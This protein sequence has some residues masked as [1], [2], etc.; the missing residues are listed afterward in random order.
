MSKIQ[1]KQEVDLGTAEIMTRSLYLQGLVSC[2]GGQ[3]IAGILER[4]VKDP[5]HTRSGFPDLTLWN[6]DNK[7]FKVLFAYFS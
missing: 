3:V 5:R 4:Y 2:M 1:D 7:T 6:T